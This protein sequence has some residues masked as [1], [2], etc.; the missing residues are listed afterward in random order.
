MRAP[1]ADQPRRVVGW[2]LLTV[3]LLATSLVYESFMIRS[4]VL[5]PDVVVDATD[6]ILERRIVQSEVADQIVEAAQS[7]LLPPG[8]TSS[9]TVHITDD[10]RQA[11]IE[12]TKTSEFRDAYATAV[13]ALHRYIFI[14]HSTA[15]VLDLSSLVPAFRDEAIA[16]NPAYAQLLPAEAPLRITITESAPDL[17]GLKRSFDRRFS[18]LAVASAALIALAMLVHSR[19]P[20]A[21]RRIGT[22]LVAFALLQGAIALLLPVLASGL[23][24]YSSII[25]EHLAR[26]LMPRLI[27]PAVAIMLFGAGA[28]ICARRWQRLHDKRNERAGAN[29]FLDPD[30]LIKI[31]GTGAPLAAAAGAPFAATG[32][33][34][35]AI[36]VFDTPT[37]SVASSSTRSRSSRRR[38]APVKTPSSPAPLFD[39]PE[40][41]S[42]P[43]D[44]AR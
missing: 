38:G 19:R 20:S 27:A 14:E 12:L 26:S 13:H 34:P 5:D 41:R 40:T 25:G 2:L 31:S 35:G 7:Q 24:G 3:G 30:Q 23:P 29:A 6:G 1:I 11:A 39:A 33:V 36:S 21:L 16:V 22:W 4:L 8:T 10:L 37:P 28:L 32:S 42:P 17:T 15:P 9:T 18:T 44:S 43:V